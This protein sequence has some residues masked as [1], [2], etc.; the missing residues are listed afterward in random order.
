[1][2]TVGAQ[3][4]RSGMS[5]TSAPAE[6]ALPPGGGRDRDPLVRELGETD[7][8]STATWLLIAFSFSGRLMA[9]KGHWTALFNGDH[10]HNC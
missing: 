8:R 9:R 5:V 2:A 6:N 3:R 4:H 1:M 7:C 10:A